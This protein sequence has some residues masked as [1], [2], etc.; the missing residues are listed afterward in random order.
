MVAA[1]AEWS[2]FGGSCIGESHQRV[3][4]TC[5]DSHGWLVG[6]N[7][8]CL[9]VAD[10]AGSRPA[11]AEGS[12]AA[13]RAVIEW[14]A[15]VDAGRAHF[16][17]PLDCILA[18]KQRI[19]ALALASG[20]PAD[21]FGTTLA[22]AYGFQDKLRLIQVGDAIG[23]VEMADGSL[24]RPVIPAGQAE[25]ANET[26]FVTG[27]DWYRHA[28]LAVLTLAEV[29]AFALSTDG[30]KMKLLTEQ[31]RLPFAPFFD[32][33]FT[34]GR[35]E[36]ASNDAIVSFISGVDDQ[37]GDDKTLLVAI[38][39]RPNAPRSMPKQIHTGPTDRS[40]SGVAGPQT[41]GSGE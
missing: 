10:G 27:L 23:V 18:A 20:R 9:A 29:H 41:T 28:G 21:D 19:A 8:V 12:E 7:I 37:T 5:E 14:A 33:L 17:D 25:Y 16:A 30:L 22:V 2:V 4:K 34:F 26:S 6:D 36:A 15:D 31:G 13:I 35:S 32:D 11:A 3:G 40:A 38:R 1:T 39:H 24:Q